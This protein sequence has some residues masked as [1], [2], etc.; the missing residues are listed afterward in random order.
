MAKAT[1]IIHKQEINQE[2]KHGQEKKELEKQL[3]KH[4]DSLHNLLSILDKID[5][6]EILSMLNAGLGES[7]Q[8]VHRIITAIQE[9]DASKSIKNLLLIIQLLGA[10][11]ME[12]L[13]PLVI[14]FNKGVEIA[15]KYEHK[16]KRDGYLSLLSALKDFEVIEGTNILLRMIKGLGTDVNEEKKTES[17]PR[18]HADKEKQAWENQEIDKGKPSK[19]YLFIGGIIILLM[20]LLFKKLR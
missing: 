10:L 12:E 13:E 14:K 9:T 17:Q 8:I 2:T 6:H 1:K 18:K 11:D 7:D 4:K 16:G 19:W 3:L 5:D 15:S 20:P